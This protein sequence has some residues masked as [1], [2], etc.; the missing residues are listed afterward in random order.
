MYRSCFAVFASFSSCTSCAAETSDPHA[1]IRA[2]IASMSCSRTASARSILS[3][4]LGALRASRSSFSRSARAAFW[5]SSESS[6]SRASVSETPHLVSSENT[7]PATPPVCAASGEKSFLLKEPLACRAATLP[8]STRTTWVGSSASANC[9]LCVTATTAPSQPRSAS[10]SASSA[11]ASRWL[12][13][14]SSSKTFTGRNTKAASATRAFSPPDKSPIV[15]STAA[16]PV[17][18]NAPNTARAVCA[19]TVGLAARATRST[20]VNGGSS[21]GSSCAKSCEK[22]PTRTSWP[23]LRTPSRH[24][25][26][27]ASARNSV[28]FPAPFGPTTKTRSPRFTLSEA[29]EN[30]AAAR[31]SYPTVAFSKTKHSRAHAGGSGSLRVT[32]LASPGPTLVS[33]SSILPPEASSSKPSRVSRTP[34]SCFARLRAAAAVLARALFF[35]TN[36]SSFCAFLVS[37]AAAAAATLRRSA[38]SERKRA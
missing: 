37:L 1:S 6:A 29:P 34:T 15:R 16:F 9:L 26:A 24:R 19:V 33:F 22:Y 21:A 11:A 4:V 27:P 32:R 20:C 13:A 10:V 14:S 35:A 17:S 12:D 36:A 7:A 25:I 8:A 28:D 18:P 3:I 2:S 31:A 30:R 23:C 5:A 38:R